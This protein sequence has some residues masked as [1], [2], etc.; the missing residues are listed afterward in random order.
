MP[1][2]SPIVSK[3]TVIFDVTVDFA[4]GLTVEMIGLPEATP[5][6]NCLSRPASEIGPIT[7]ASKLPD[8]Q[9]SNC[10]S[11]FGRFS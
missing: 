10:E 9:S 4:T 7:I 3:S 8:R 6:A 11:C 1:V 5:L 2:C